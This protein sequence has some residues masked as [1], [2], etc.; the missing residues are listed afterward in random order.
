MIKPLGLRMFPQSGIRTVINP[1]I[2]SIQS[3]LDGF[4][5]GCS[6]MPAKYSVAGGRSF[7]VCSLTSSNSSISGGGRNT[8][9][10]SSVLNDTGVK[11][12]TSGIRGLVSELSDKVV[13]QAMTAFALDGIARGK[14][15]AGDRILLGGDLR[16]STPHLMGIAASAFKHAGLE[17]LNAGLLPTPALAHYARVNNMPLMV[18]TGSHIPFDRNGLKPYYS[19]GEI[20]KTDEV[21][22][23]SHNISSMPQQ[24]QETHLE[25]LDDVNASVTQLYIDR[26][27]NAF[28]KNA[29]QGQTLIFQAH[30][31]V[32]RDIIPSLLRSLGATVE[33]VDRRDEF[34]AVDTEAVLP[35]H[36]QAVRGFMTQYSNATAF[37]T[38]DGDSDRPFLADEQGNMISG[39]SLGLIVSRQLGA[40]VNVIP[41]SSNS[42]ID[43]RL[44]G[45]VHTKIGSPY[46]IAEMSNHSGRVVGWEANGGFLLG[47]DIDM[48]NGYTLQSLPTRDAVLPIVA[49]L[50]RSNEKKINL[51]ELL[52]SEEIDSHVRSSGL[53]RGIEKLDSMRILSPLQ[54]ASTEDLQNFMISLGVSGFNVSH[55]NATDGL[56]I[57]SEKGEVIHFR[58]SGNEPALRCYAEAGSAE[59]AAYLSEQA[60]KGINEIAKKKGRYVS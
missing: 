13:F 28:G 1:G 46:V 30:S 29:L 41:I 34:M 12:G 50:I 44:E 20:L 18:V 16:P 4:S 3:G 19:T 26:Y 11:F 37:I 8:T 51:S 58:P 7:G 59:R 15:N 6:A 25:D 22:I 53:I 49:A 33:I 14:I 47:S 23:L 32:G 27:V 57:Y 55:V 2:C 42:I 39:D 52:K 9:N 48:G 10:L 36:I 54:S 5:M 21:S 56:R 24:F 17:P 60:L 35:E 43:T 40:D 45:V 38:T 31:A